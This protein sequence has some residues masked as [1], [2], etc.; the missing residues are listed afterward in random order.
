MKIAVGLSGGVDS[1]VA[2][3]LLKREG[4]EVTGITMRIVE[5]F[6]DTGDDAR[7]VAE[8]LGISHHVID[9]REEYEKNIL[10]YIRDDYGAGRTPNPCVRCNREVKF[11]LF[12]SRARSLD[13]EFAYFATGHFARIRKNPETG[14]L[15][16]AGGTHSEKDQA[17]FL[18]LLTQEQLSS[19][20]FPWEI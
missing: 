2:A 18:S 17:Y 10:Q 1:S 16:L 5:D 15:S 12:L 6:D 19:I 13:I 14:R 7:R 4:H 20:L 9:L 8:H 3:L 11:G